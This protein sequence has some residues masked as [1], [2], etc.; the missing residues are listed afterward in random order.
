MNISRRHNRVVSFG[1]YIA[2]DKLFLDSVSK[3]GVELSFNVISFLV[4]A[5]MLFN[6]LNAM[7]MDG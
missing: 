7:L 1:L 2:S 3:I 6:Y 5:Y 4:E